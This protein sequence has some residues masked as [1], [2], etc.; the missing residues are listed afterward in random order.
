[1]K[2]PAWLNEEGQTADLHSDIQPLAPSGETGA[3]L[4]ELQKKKRRVFWGLKILTIM[5]C[6]LMML[7]AAIGLTE[8][9]GLE[10][11]GRVFVAVYMLF[12]ATLLLTFEVIQVRPCEQIDFMFKRNFGFLY[13]TKGK[14]FFIIFV[15]FLSFGLT[16]PATL[17][18]FTGLMLAGLG[19][20]EI[21]L[22]LKWPELFDE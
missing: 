20:L 8:L 13:S 7:T 9:T 17:C 4:T 11:A 22:Y 14:A 10:A 1:M 3:P 6:I 12:F 15:A 19:A 5:L 2:Q 16:E 18:L 21:G